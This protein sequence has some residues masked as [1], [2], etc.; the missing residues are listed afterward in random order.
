MIT[1]ANSS[2][3]YLEDFEAIRAKLVELEKKYKQ[4]YD[5]ANSVVCHVGAEGDIDSRHDLLL[6][7]LFVLKDHDDGKV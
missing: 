3:L 4:L 6:N 5:A 1:H 7:L 2:R